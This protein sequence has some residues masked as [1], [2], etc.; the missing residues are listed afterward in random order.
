[1]LD[2][3]EL[4]IPVDADNPPP[5]ALFDVTDPVPIVHAA[6]SAQPVLMAGD[7]EGIVDAAAAGLLDGNQLVLESAALDGQTLARALHDGADI[8]LTDSNRRTTKHYF[9]RIRDAS[10]YTER[11]GQNARHDDDTF[12][13]EPFPG[14]ADSARTV[15]EQHGAEVGASDYAV[16][17]DRPA[18]AF[19]GDLRTAWRVSGDAVGDRLVVSPDRPVRTDHVTLTQL[20]GTKDDRTIDDVRLRFDGGDPI[21]VHLGAESR[22]P[23]GQVVTFPERN[24]HKLEIEILNVHK[25]EID[26]LP[27]VVGFTEVGLGDVRVR[28]TVR[29][30]VDLSRRAGAKADGHRLDVVLSRLRY[31]PGQLQ[32]EELALDRRFVLPDAWSFELTGTARVDPN[33]PDPLLD[34]TLGTAIPGAVFT[35][36]DHLFG[37]ADARASRAFDADPSTAWTP[38][39]GP[40]QGRWIDVQLPEPV[41]VDHVDLT[42]V[43]DD[44]HSVPTQFTLAVDGTPLRTFTIAPVDDGKPGTTRTV[45]VPFDAVT[46]HELRLY[47]DAVRPKETTAQLRRPKIEAPV[48]IAEIGVPGVPQAPAVGSLS[49]ACRSDLLRVNRAPVPI[50]IV[51]TTAEAR[52]GLAIES[53]AGPVALP[54]GSNTVRS[55][56]GLDTAIDVD[57]VVLSSSK[58]GTATPPVPLGA[59]LDESGAKVRRGRLDP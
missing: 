59:P 54:A 24:V 14:S 15:V 50:R 42:F 38:N 57:R 46:G 45:T 30:P 25:P 40:Q 1:M 9:A 11:A 22:T 47:V 36:A 19:D 12:V 48:A 26:R 28:E 31:D 3:V 2:N 10:G 37:D 13:L 56:T 41:T 8:V 33:A 34:N 43:A 7:G 39:F 29:L 44:R 5:V 17:A 18:N 23:D 27:R 49:D 4:R 55:A 20:F 6:P 52:S 58:R 53:C 32:D 21:D 51:G 16:A 35:S